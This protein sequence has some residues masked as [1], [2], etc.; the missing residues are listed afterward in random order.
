MFKVD[1]VK[2]VLKVPQISGVPAPGIRDLSQSSGPPTPEFRPP[3]PRIQGHLPLN[4]GTPKSLKTVFDESN[5][6][7]E[8]FKAKF[9]YNPIQYTIL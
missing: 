5:I 8:G 2:L 4:S 6:D 9:L 1:Y 7:L 3:Y